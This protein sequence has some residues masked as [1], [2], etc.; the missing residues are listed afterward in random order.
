MHPNKVYVSTAASQQLNMLAQ[1]TS[2]RPN[3]S[4]RLGICLSL[5]EYGPPTAEEFGGRSE[6]EFNWSTLFG[7]LDMLYVAMVKQ[8]LAEDGMDPELDFEEQLHR[9]LNRGVFLL[10]K[11]LKRLE[12]LEALLERAGTS[13]ASTL[14]E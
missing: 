8:R 5:E 6:R 7:Q 12:D 14:E 11:R 3:I 2:L 4:C 9:H 1:R 13:T 10:F